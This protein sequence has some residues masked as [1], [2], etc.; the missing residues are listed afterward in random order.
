MAMIYVR[1]RSMQANPTRLNS[2]Y[3]AANRELRPLTPGRLV[4]GQLTP[5]K[6]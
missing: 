2:G 4:P 3:A 5:G 6:L 1:D